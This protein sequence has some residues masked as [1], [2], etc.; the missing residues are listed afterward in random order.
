M[1]AAP[2]ETVYVRQ[3]SNCHLPMRITDE[4]KP[5]DAPGAS[6]AKWEPPSGKGGWN[7]AAG[8]GVVAEGLAAQQFFHSQSL[9]NSA[10]NDYTANG[11]YKAADLAS[12]SSAKT[13]HTN[14]T[15]FTAVGAGLI[16]VGGVLFFVF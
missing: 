14:S 6:A 9:A 12:I 15:I 11:Y 10:A 7:R 5:S 1:R 13:A 3:L 4:A 2:V 8:L 16:V